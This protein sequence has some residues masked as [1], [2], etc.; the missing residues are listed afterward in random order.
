MFAIPVYNQHGYLF[1]NV[2]KVDPIFTSRKSKYENFTLPSWK[3]KQ[4]YFIENE[5][6]TKHNHNENHYSIENYKIIFLKIL[7]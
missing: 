7:W 2:I 1:N 6:T 5:V 4:Y 3:K